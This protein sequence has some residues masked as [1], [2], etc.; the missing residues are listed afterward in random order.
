ML[1][2]FGVNTA[3]GL[4]GLTELLQ[5]GSLYLALVLSCFHSLWEGGRDVRMGSKPERSKP[6]RAVTEDGSCLSLLGPP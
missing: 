1:S 3:R 4:G 5:Q 2:G 6:V